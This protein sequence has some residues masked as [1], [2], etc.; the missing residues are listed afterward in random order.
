MPA[1]CGREGSGGRPHHSRS[2]AVLVLPALNPAAVVPL[3]HGHGLRLRELALEV[4]VHDLYLREG[5]RRFDHL[6]GRTPGQPGEGRGGG[7]G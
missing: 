2:L 6:G 7:H 3:D 1:S 5:L 4:R